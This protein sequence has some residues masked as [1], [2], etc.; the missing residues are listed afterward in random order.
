MKKSLFYPYLS[1]NLTYLDNPVLLVHEKALGLPILNLN[2]SES[3][4]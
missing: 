3:E 2:L 1:E 4:K